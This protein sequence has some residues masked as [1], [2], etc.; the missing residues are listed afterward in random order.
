MGPLPE[1]RRAPEGAADEDLYR[2]YS[3]ARDE[4]ALGALVRRH[5]ERLFRLA[6]RIVRD[7]AIAEDVAQQ[8]LVKAIGRGG[9]RGEG[10]LVGW[11]TR[12][13]VNEARNASLA[14]RRRSRHEEVAGA[15][16]IGRPGGG[17]ED[18]GDLERRELEAALDAHLD[19]LPEDLRVPL[20]LRYCE[21]LTHEE[22]AQALG[23]A[24]GT[25]SSR[26]RRALERLRESLA[27]AGFAAALPSLSL[28]TLLARVPP[29]PAAPPP[30]SA[31]LIAARIARLKSGALKLFAG[32]AGALAAITLAGA[33]F[34]ATGST[35]RAGGG[36]KRSPDV[37]RAPATAAEDSVGSERIRKTPA[38]P[39][40]ERTAAQA[41]PSS[42]LSLSEA[43]DSS[44][45]EPSTAPSKTP[46]EPGAPREALLPSLIEGR[47]ISERD[48]APVAGAEIVVYLATIEGPGKSSTSLKRRTG[49][50]GAFRIAADDE[51]RRLA[52]GAIAIDYSGR[53]K[54]VD[55]VAIAI[56]HEGFEP[57][58]APLTEEEVRAHA[59]LLL[60][61][62]P[63]GLTFAA[64]VIDGATRV[65]IEGV[66]V[67]LSQRQELGIPAL[68]TPYHAEAKSGPG[69]TL[70]V[71]GL[72]TGNLEVKVAD[73]RYGGKTLAFALSAGAAGPF[74]IEL[75]PAARVIVEAV[76]AA[77]DPIPKGEVALVGG[78]YKE[79]ELH[80]GRAVL[81]G[82]AAGEGYRV[83]VSRSGVFG[84][85]VVDGEW[86]LHAEASTEPF[87]IEAG[88]EKTVRL[89]LPAR[90][91][92]AAPAAEEP[93]PPAWPATEGTRRIA[94]AVVDPEGR[95]VAGAS[96]KLFGAK[97]LEDGLRLSSPIDIP[98][99]LKFE[100]APVE[101]ESDGHFAIEGLPERGAFVIVVTAPGFLPKYAAILPAGLE[102]ASIPAPPGALDDVVPAGAPTENLTL[103]LFRAV[104][105]SVE[106][107]PPA[108]LAPERLALSLQAN[109]ELAADDV[110]PLTLPRRPRIEPTPGGSVR[111][112]F[113][114]ARP[115]ERGTIAL[116]LAGWGG[117]I[118]EDL[119]AGEPARE[120]ALAPGATLRG[121]IFLADG[122]PAAGA[123]VTP[124]TEGGR[125]VPLWRAEADTEGRF[126]LADFPPGRLSL[127]ISLEGHKPRTI[128]ADTRD[129]PDLGE[130]RID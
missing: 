14:R 125:E 103:R 84:A 124:V 20:V 2:R 5:W 59:P 77:G 109:L 101:T 24:S 46:P 73:D 49:A 108:G 52:D 64:R 35:D 116:R 78:E 68:A 38:G 71:G 25:A 57:L 72:A 128:A 48:G 102:R 3:E 87:S 82:V 56:H 28:E 4:E 76:D 88:E 17:S 36:A 13:V 51:R 6:W 118:V 66:A 85:E 29:A 115:G 104:P 90:K 10:T 44:P 15:A 60:R 97:V 41:A 21:G 100:R 110:D 26:V 37:A 55:R 54:V 11:L 107:R 93:A 83:L 33:I 16:R 19:R 39:A 99:E 53:V 43:E 50:D 1:S 80:E 105:F 127:R 12:I 70:R 92:E 121:R 69:G 91:G 31:A 18:L 94:G 122:R 114:G 22:V 96:V 7:P 30:P 75:E 126:V 129:G 120:V 45:I 40:R 123:R 98:P 32:V 61:M 130:V 62:R 42:G 8:S 34:L 95:P 113:D 111:V 23:L 79:E 67:E 74:E 27:E 63:G 119:T 58:F 89:V 81:G 112:A 47:V 117:L 86:R 106:V 65:P 9:W